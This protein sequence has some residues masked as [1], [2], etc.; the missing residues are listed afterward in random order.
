PDGSAGAPRARSE[1]RRPDGLRAAGAEDAQLR[2][3]AENADGPEREHDEP[4][5]EQR[6]IDPR[7]AVE[8]RQRRGPHRRDP[9]APR[10]RRALAADPGPGGDRDAAPSAARLRLA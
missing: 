9:R 4:D 6:A 2:A 7:A 1:R 5:Q 8:R 3:A 10:D